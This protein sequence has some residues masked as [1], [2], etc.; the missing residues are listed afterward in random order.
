MQMFSVQ[1]I[2]HG[3]IVFT[4]S[5][6]FLPRVGE[7]LIVGEHIFVVKVIR[8]NIREGVGTVPVTL[9]LDSNI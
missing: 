4:G 2:H 8:Y 5:L 3:N 6:N 9:F 7:Q 1:A